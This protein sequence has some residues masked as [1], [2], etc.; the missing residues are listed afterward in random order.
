MSIKIFTPPGQRSLLANCLLAVSF[1][2][3]SSCEKPA[4]QPVPAARQ[5]GQVGQPQG[6][7]PFSVANV[8]QAYANLLASNKKSAQLVVKPTTKNAATSQSAVARPIEPTPAP[9]PDPTP[10]TTP[11]PPP[12][13]QPTHWY[14]RFKPAD[15]NQLADLG[16]LGYELSWEPL[17]ESVAAV[18]TVDY[19]S[20]DIPWIYTVLPAGTTLPSA[21]AS[22]HLEDLYLFN[23]EDGDMQDSD[24][25]TP[26][27]TPTPPSCF[28]QWSAT[29][30]RYQPCQSVKT[31]GGN[32][33]GTPQ[34][35]R[36]ALAAQRIKQAGISPHALYNEVMRLSGHA[37]EL[38]DQT[39][40]IA[41]SSSPTQTQL[42]G[43]RYHPRGKILVQDTEL[44]N[45]PLRG[46]EVKSRRWFQFGSTFTDDQGNFAISTSYRSLAK[47][48][49]YFK[50]NLA[51]TRGIV[52]GF[53]FW[54]AV[55]PISAGIGDYEDDDMERVY[56]TVTAQ[57]GLNNVNSKG[58]S[59]W[60]ACTLFNALAE[61]RDFSLA[62]GLPT[63]PTDINVWLFPDFP[64]SSGPGATPMLRKIASTS[65]VSQIIDFLLLGSGRSDL[66]L[67]K[68]V[69]QRQLPDVSIRYGGDQGT[70]PTFRL[71]PLLYHELGHA[72]HYSQVG[73]NFWT[74]FIALTVQHGGYGD[75]SDSGSG[76]MA[77]S[78]GWAN[79]TE[80]LFTI[81]KYQGTVQSI[82]SDGALLEL[83]NQIP[84]SSNRTVTV[85]GYY[86]EGW[87][88]FGLYHDMTDNSEPTFTGVTDNVDAFTPAMVFHGLQSNVSTVRDY[89]ALINSQ[90]AGT[91][92]AQLNQLVTSYQ[93]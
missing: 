15:L 86:T 31:S 77:V 71:K 39:A 55:L 8:S 87:L 90:T 85:P 63:A 4:L 58:A 52:T 53:R 51:T 48:S 88:I 89:Q 43:G 38:L 12:P 92:A 93:W 41:V 68:Q 16:D 10:P 36:Q 19:Q 45:V 14:L 5:A 24:P 49:L 81:A 61:D 26:D 70:I 56:Y 25:W 32:R 44:G 6:T 27:P 7:N 2:L 65:A 67:I 75:K 37:D 80:R 29:T 3:L 1:L 82:R 17:D 54:D 83:E 22:E 35:S 69:V 91:Q 66:A 33:V 64:P 28:A 59:T 18:T 23:E 60:A 21:I 46:V 40:E 20:A 42:F 34:P 72:Q 9:D 50:N 13:L 57:Q 84:S 47:L 79:Y 30:N 76:R 73:N 78:E 11:S 62:R 74:V